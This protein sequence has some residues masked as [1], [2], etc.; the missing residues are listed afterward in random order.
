[1]CALLKPTTKKL[2]Q[3]TVST[4]GLHIST[5]LHRM[6]ERALDVDLEALDSVGRTALMWA[7]ELGHVE[8]VEALLELGADRQTADP[9]R[10]RWAPTAQATMA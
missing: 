1:M 6:V 2:L 3:S 8:T 9:Q 10:G 4:L 5:S 7:A